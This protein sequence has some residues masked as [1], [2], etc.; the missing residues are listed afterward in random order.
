MESNGYSSLISVRHTPFLHLLNCLYLNWWVSS[1]WLFLF[2]PSSCLGAVRKPLGGGLAAAQG[3]HTTISFSDFFQLLPLYCIKAVHSPDTSSW[4]TNYQKDHWLQ[5]E[6]NREKKTK[7]WKKQPW[8]NVVIF[9]SNYRQKIHSSQ[10]YANTGKMD[11]GKSLSW[12]CLRSCSGMW[13]KVEEMPCHL[14]ELR[15]KNR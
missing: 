14:S 4:T 10:S 11:Y 8:S 13:S 2:R 15:K 3:Q 9:T 12:S 7:S 1:L 5:N 6:R